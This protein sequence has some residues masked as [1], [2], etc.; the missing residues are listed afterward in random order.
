MRFLIFTLSFLVAF[1]AYSQTPGKILFSAIVVDADSVP[2]TGVAIINSL[3][4]KTI[5]TNEHG[6]FQTEYDE[7]D[8]LFIYHIGFERQFA[9]DDDNGRI[10]VLVPRINELKQ[11]NVNNNSIEDLKYFQQTI[12]DIKRLASKK[13]IADYNANSR[14]QKFIDQYGSLTKGFEP[15]FGPTVH[16]PFTKLFALVSVNEN[17][18]HL[19]KLTSHYHYIK[20]KKKK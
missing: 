1:Q 5:H 11:V 20:A 4:G 10:I 15:Y 17:K 9:G 8:S 6:Y 7:G 19:K 18:Q 12:N 13:K 14:Q 3:T 16:V 2:V